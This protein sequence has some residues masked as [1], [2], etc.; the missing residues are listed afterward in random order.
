MI[1]GLYQ[2]AAG[3]MTNEYRQNVISNNL[4]NA[5]TVGFKRD[6]AVFSERLRER[7]PDRYSNPSNACK[8]ARPGGLCRAERRG[9]RNQGQAGQ[10]VSER[11]CG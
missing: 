9:R 8:R 7:E 3:M 6:V 1:Y 5:Q 10:A 11:R 2:S 4:A